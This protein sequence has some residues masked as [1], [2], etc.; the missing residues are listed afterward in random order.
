MHIIFSQVTT[1][2]FPTIKLQNSSLDTSKGLQNDMLGYHGQYNGL[3]FVTNKHNPLVQT[4]V[5][6]IIRMD[7]DFQV[8][9]TLILTLK[10]NQIMILK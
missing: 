4:C 7:H 6:V 5:G 9:L 3:F 1:L 2:T 8:V 10:T